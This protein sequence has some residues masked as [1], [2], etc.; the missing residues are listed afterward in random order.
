[1]VPV[2]LG[3]ALGPVLLALGLAIA[4]VGGIL[5][6]L[7]F[8]GA[9]SLAYTIR[10]KELP[11]V[12]VFCLTFLYVVRLFAG[13]LATGFH[14]SQWLVGFSTFFFLGL[15]FIKRVAELSTA[16]SDSKKMSRRGYLPED[17]TMLNMM[18]VSSSFISCVL[19]ALFVQ[20][21]EVAARYASPATL[22]LLVPLIL[23]WQLRLWL[24]T[25]R[26]YML[27]DP[28][29]YGARDWVSWVAFATVVAI[30]ILANHSFLS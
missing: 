29:I 6:A 22:W 11:L 19:L 16:Q 13:G 14:V 5:S 24:S 4:W 8:Y 3:M 23:F 7:A 28:I 27:D 18:G 15:A 10:A 20:S 12:D 30:M 9:V 25:T 1:M 21:P 26:G 17:V 2:P